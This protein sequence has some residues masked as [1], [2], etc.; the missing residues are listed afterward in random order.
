MPKPLK[1]PL[2]WRQVLDGAERLDTSHGTER[3]GRAV[4]TAMLARAVELQP[5]R[6]RPRSVFSAKLFAKSRPPALSPLQQHM[7]ERRRKAYEY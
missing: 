7:A 4:I 3:Y 2:T 6:P 5:P 1:K